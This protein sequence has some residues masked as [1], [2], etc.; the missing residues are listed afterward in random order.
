MICNKNQSKFLLVGCEC[1]YKIEI[2]EKGYVKPKIEKIKSDRLTY[3]FMILYGDKELKYLTD[4]EHD[5]DNSCLSC[6]KNDKKYNVFTTYNNNN[7]KEIIYLCNSCSL[8]LNLI[9]KYGNCKNCKD[10]I[11]TK[12]Y[13]IINNKNEYYKYCKYCKLSYRRCINCKKEK[14][15]K[16]NDHC[17][18]CFDVLFFK[19]NCLTCDK[20]EIIKRKEK[21]WNKQCKKC[22]SKTKK[23]W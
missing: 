15:C 2:R 10:F 3:E 12:D 22:W 14:I 1:Y 6:K 18:D 19:R 5:E 21:H 11:T 7:H 20:I 23:V 8:S 17:Y 4:C 13:M 16:Y 9:G